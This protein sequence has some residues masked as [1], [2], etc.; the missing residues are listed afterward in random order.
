MKARTY[1]EASAISAIR[2]GRDQLLRSNAGR[3]RRRSMPRQAQYD[4][5]RDR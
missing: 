5:S 3:R 2:S 1:K 4:G